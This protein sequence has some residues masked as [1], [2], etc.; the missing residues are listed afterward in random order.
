MAATV[1]R[2]KMM[3]PATFA[4]KLATTFANTTVVDVIAS[5]LDG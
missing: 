2:T 1:T 4:T 5:D 3:F